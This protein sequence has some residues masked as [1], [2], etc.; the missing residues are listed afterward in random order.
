[1]VRSWNINKIPE[2]GSKS[3]KICQ[4][5]ANIG[6]ST[7]LSAEI[8]KNSKGVAQLSQYFENL[9]KLANTLLTH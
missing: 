1:M 9:L 7:V 6:I 5:I 4:E 8:I 3:P 2:L